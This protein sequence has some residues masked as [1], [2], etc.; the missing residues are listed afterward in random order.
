LRAIDPTVAVEHV[1]T[2]EQIRAESFAP[3]TFAMRLLVGF[4]L[5]G[6][7]LAVVGIYGVLSLSV[8]SRKREMAIRSAVGAQRWDVLSLVLSQG[9]RLV[10]VG[11][12]LGF[13]AAVGLARVLR[14]FLYG[15]GPTDPTTFLGVA[16]LFTGV[17]LL[18]CLVPAL[19]ATRI[20]P[21]AA[22]RCE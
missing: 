22:L 3:Q 10:A 13:V 17:A 15:V 4:S 14:G 12:V 1:K 2:L 9:L 16:L 20:D 7:V 18:A 6:S 8:G 11:L 21:M 5:V 19:R